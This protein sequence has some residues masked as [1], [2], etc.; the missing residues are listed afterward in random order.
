M[1]GPHQICL[2]KNCVEPRPGHSFWCTFLL[3][4]ASEGGH[5]RASERGSAVVW[6]DCKWSGPFYYGLGG[7]GACQNRL[8]NFC[9]SRAAGPTFMYFF[10]LPEKERV[11]CLATHEARD[12]IFRWFLLCRPPIYLL[13]RASRVW[14]AKRVV[15]GRMPRAF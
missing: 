13:R 14:N 2:V 11:P 4:C 15:G 10:T 8:G 7:L 9:L 1:F 12:H 5:C 6:T 3:S